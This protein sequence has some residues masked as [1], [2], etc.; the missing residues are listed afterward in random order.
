MSRRIYYVSSI[1]FNERFF[2]EVIIDPHYE[3]KHSSYMTD[4]LIIDLVKKLHGKED[5]PTDHKEEFSYYSKRIR[6]DQKFYRLVWV[7][8]KDQFYIGVINAFRVR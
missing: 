6:F 3:E 5:E 4:K 8:E 1:Y 2:G 7:L